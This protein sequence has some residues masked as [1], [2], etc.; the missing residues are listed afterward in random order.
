M[1]LCKKNN[2]SKIKTEGSKIVIEVKEQNY[3]HKFN[4][5]EWLI[6]AI[7]RECHL[8]KEFE[9]NNNK[10]VKKQHAK[11]GNKNKKN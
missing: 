3:A 5:K 9:K 7:A 1:Y 8:H 11:K 4:K 2:D 10:E 6:I